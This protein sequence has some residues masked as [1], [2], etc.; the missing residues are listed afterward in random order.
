MD[1]ICIYGYR[2]SN[3]RLHEERESEIDLGRET[4]SSLVLFFFFVLA[5]LLPGYTLSSLLTAR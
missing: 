2:L 5:R 3:S 1:G 4:P